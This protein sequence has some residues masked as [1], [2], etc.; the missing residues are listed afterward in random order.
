MVDEANKELPILD[1]SNHTLDSI[2]ISCP[3]VKGVLLHLK[4]TK[5][6]ELGSP[7]LLR[8]GPISLALPYSFIFNRSHDPE[9]FPNYWKEAN[10]TPIYKKDYIPLPNNYRP[11]S[12]LSQSA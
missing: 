12:L 8:E 7:R 10:V 2:L 5:P 1:P 6:S 9:Y 3:D 4:V 11:M